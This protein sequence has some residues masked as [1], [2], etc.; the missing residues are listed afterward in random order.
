VSKFYQAINI[1]AKSK[2]EGFSQMASVQMAKKYAMEQSIKNVLVKQ[3]VS[4]QQQQVNQFL[5]PVFKVTCSYE[6]LQIG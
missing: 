6:C 4:Q 5:R 2:T 3:T 1:S